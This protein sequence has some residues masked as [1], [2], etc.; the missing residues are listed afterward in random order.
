MSFLIMRRRRVSTIVMRKQ[1][2]EL[3]RSG[4]EGTLVALRG[5]DRQKQIT[6]PLSSLIQKVRFLPKLRHFRAKKRHSSRTVAR[7]TATGRNPRILHETRGFPVH[8]PTHERQ[9]AAPRN[10]RFARKNFRFPTKTAVS[11]LRF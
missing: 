10:F 1:I 4:A 7:H 8:R 11:P 3:L 9:V 5:F 2:G 6:N